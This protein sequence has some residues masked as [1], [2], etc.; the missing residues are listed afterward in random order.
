MIRRP[1]RSTRTDT[2]FPYTTLFRSVLLVGELQ[3]GC[4]PA[5]EPG[6]RGDAVLQGQRLAFLRVVQLRQRLVSA[7]VDVAPLQA[8]A[9]ARTAFGAVTQARGVDVALGRDRKSTRLNS[10]H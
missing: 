7:F 10:S 3:A 2:F 8:Q 5:V 9:H 6:E 4:I 1:P